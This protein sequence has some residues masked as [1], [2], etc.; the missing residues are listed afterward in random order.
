MIIN[1]EESRRFVAEIARLLKSDGEVK[2]T[3][4]GIFKVK[5]KAQRN[6][7]NPRTGEALIIPA[8]KKIAF[9]LSSIL[10]KIV[11]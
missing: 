3:G 8:G 2:I 11:L 7:R 4:L 10:K 5:D 1:T 6:V 9:R